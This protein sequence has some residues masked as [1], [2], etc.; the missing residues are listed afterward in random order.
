MNSENLQIPKAL[1]NIQDSL[2][3]IDNHHNYFEQNSI[4]PYK[5]TEPD[6]D[7]TRR[8]SDPFHSFIE[9]PKS[10]WRIVDTEEFQRL[11]YIKQLGMTGFVFNG[12]NHT[13]F[14]HCLGVAHL[15]WTYLDKIAINHQQKYDQM[16]L[17]DADHFDQIK[18]LVTI[19]G[20]CHD[21]GHG[22]FSHMF[23]NVLLPRLG[24]K[25]WKH[26]EGSCMMLKSILLGEEKDFM[27]NLVTYKNAKLNPKED[28]QVILDMIEGLTLEQWQDK[29]QEKNY[30]PKWIFDIVSN[31]TTSID[32]DK[33]DYLKRD[34]SCLNVKHE[35]DYNILFNETR[36]INGEICYNSKIH[37]TIYD[38]FHIRYKL[39]KHIYL[40]RVTQAIELML[41][42]ALEKADP[43]I[44]FL[45]T[46]KSPQKY[47]RLTD[48]V[49]ELIMNQYNPELVES[50]QIL[51]R[52]FTRKLYKFVG[53]TVVDYKKDLTESQVLDGISRN[54]QYKQTF[55]CSSTKLND[56]ERKNTIVTFSKINYCMKDQDPVTNCYFYKSSKPDEKRKL[57]SQNSSLLRPQK[58]GEQIIR[59]FVKENDE[60]LINKVKNGFALFTQKEL[61]T[62]TSAYDKKDNTKTPNKPEPQKKIKL[63]SPQSE[64]N[65]NSNQLQMN[66]MV[67]VSH[68][69][70]RNNKMLFQQDD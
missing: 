33:L 36:I 31:K 50:Q 18:L 66:L 55:S 15:S 5:E 57:P 59:V 68:A 41:C 19:A 70:K 12:A 25:K 16:G 1:Q 11:R 46:I 30:Y 62:E 32:V 47:L 6:W 20:L 40:H 56:F 34:P 22:P 38:I 7:E 4:N 28:I 10:I 61:H 2:T 60:V 52:I 8:I 3:S 45:E 53:E 64:N 17:R 63:N 37:D 65:E 44:N 67:S 54:N 23:D 13:R 14:E 42:D 69:L 21:L 35:F 48:S 26:E 51:Q 49:I 39:F 29:Y 27:T 9:L 24:D 43:Q 58:F